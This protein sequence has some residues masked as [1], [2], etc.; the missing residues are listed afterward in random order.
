MP[1]YLHIGGVIALGFSSNGSHLLVVSHDG[2]GV[3][4]INS[5]KKI[6]RDRSA[7]YPDNGK[8]QGIGPL[9]G[10]TVEVTE[11]DYDTGLMAVVSPDDK[12][13]FYYETGTVTITE[14]S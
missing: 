1:H 10:Q 12:Y 8:V 14:H 5:W 2:I 4:E 11:I 3:F 6:A 9:A 7:S 13:L